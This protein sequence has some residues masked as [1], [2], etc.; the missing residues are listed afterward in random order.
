MTLSLMRSKRLIFCALL[1]LMA[2]CT[3]AMQ[4][5]V[6]IPDVE[7]YESG[8]KCYVPHGIKLV[9]WA[10]LI[11]AQEKQDLFIQGMGLS[12]KDGNAVIYSNIPEGDMVEK[13]PMNPK[14]SGIPYLGMQN[15]ISLPY[16]AIAASFESSSLKSVQK[17]CEQ[18]DASTIQDQLEKEETLR[19]RLKADH[20]RVENVRYDQ[21][22]TG[23]SPAYNDDQKPIM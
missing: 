4:T 7:R 5:G 18:K 8:N 2:G 19:S 15:L 22:R 17:E 23:D 20:Q 21:L 1:P 14:N 11:D 13:D 12:K 10:N 9:H 3:T 16:T 6:F